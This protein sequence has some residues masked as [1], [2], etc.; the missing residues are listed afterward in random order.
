MK[1]IVYNHY[2]KPDVLEEQELD[3]PLLKPKKILI[4]VHAAGVNPKDW[5]V[6]KGKFQLFTK[7]EFPKQLGY[8]FAG[9]VVETGVGI[10]TV[11]PGAPVYG[12]ING[13]TGTT[14]AE[15]LIAG[16]N[17]LSPMPDNLT[18]AQSAAAPLAA[19][20]AL[21]ALRDIGKVRAG[22][23]VC[24]NGASGGVG[25]YAVQ[26]AKAFDSQVTGICSNANAELVTRLGADRVID[27]HS[28]NILKQDKK[29]DI[30][31]DVFGNSNFKKVKQ[32]LKPGGIYISTIPSPAR[33]VK[34]LWHRINPIGKEERLVVV[35]SK[36]QDLLFLKEL[37]EKEKIIPIVDKT[38]PL[39]Q[40]RDAHTY[41]ET[42]RARGKIVLKVR[43]RETP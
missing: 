33:L 7:K 24:I 41:V 23:R 6:R 20:T 11:K 36:T 21:Q 3:T 38:F 43:D 39:S 9:V 18:F 26:I 2:G 29:Y 27:Y 42:K 13:W 4:K 10:D 35:K 34:D 31:F 5:L 30:F 17:E 16:P 15:Y 28:Q 37:I 8:D 14:Y 1:A 32:I 22:H 12:M 25:T 19:Q 40:A